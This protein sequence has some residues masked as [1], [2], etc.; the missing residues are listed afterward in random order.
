MNKPENDA[1][2]ERLR[3]LINNVLERFNQENVTPQE[4]GMVILGLTHRLM[5]VLE[6]TPEVRRQFIL[7]FINLVNQYLSGD[8]QEE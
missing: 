6:G 8:F 7:N 2:N 3:L 1:L 4:A 5:T